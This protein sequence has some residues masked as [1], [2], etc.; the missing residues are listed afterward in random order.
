MVSG[1]PTARSKKYPAGLGTQ[2]ELRERAVFFDCLRYTVP[3]AASYEGYGFPTTGKSP[4]R[5]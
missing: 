4:R 5:A 3:G 2:A 1:N